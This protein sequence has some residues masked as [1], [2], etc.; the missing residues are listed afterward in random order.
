MASE[1]KTLADYRKEAKREPFTLPLDDNRVI[2]IKPPTGATLMDLDT[3][4]TTR[5]VLKLIVGDQYDELIEAIGEE[6]GAV[7][8]AIGKDMQKHFGLGGFNASPA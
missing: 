8:M 2:V 1:T 6:D 3:A 7:L 4:Y 5:A